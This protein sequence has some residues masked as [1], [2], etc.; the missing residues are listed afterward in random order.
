ML[1]H[2]NWVI[3]SLLSTV[4][5]VTCAVGDKALHTMTNPLAK[6]IIDNSVHGAIGFFSALIILVDQRD[7]VNCL[8]LTV[9]CAVMS[10]LIDCDHFVAAR[11]LKLA[12][13]KL[14][15]KAETV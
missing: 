10:S 13:R 5:A 11:S 1:V 14:Q 9:A 12:V 7:P 6:A 8:Q 4:I 2:K 15:L 3:N